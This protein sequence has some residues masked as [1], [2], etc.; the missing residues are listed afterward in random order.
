V[1]VRCGKVP[2]ARTRAGVGSARCIS[3]ETQ[4]RFLS[5]PGLR[6]ARP[7]ILLRRLSPAIEP[8][9][10]RVSWPSPL[11]RRRPALGARDLSLPSSID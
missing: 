8:S 11:R 3:G 7:E 4:G 1:R 2:D 5:G 10:G 9:P 6:R